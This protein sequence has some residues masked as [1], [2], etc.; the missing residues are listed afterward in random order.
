MII[1][2]FNNKGG[3]GK[4][5]YLYHLAHTIARERKNVLMVD[6]DPQCNLTSY[7][8]NDAAIG[9]SFDPTRGNSLYLAIEPLHQSMGDIRDR[10][11]SQPQ[12]V[13]YPTLWL[14]PGD[15]SLSEFEDTLGDTWVRAKGG[16]A[17]DVRKQSGIFRFIS[18]AAEKVDAEFTFIDLGPNLGPLNRTVLACCD[19][20]IVPVAPDLFSIRGTEN[21]GKKLVTWG[22]EWTQIAEA[23][24][25]RHEIAIPN[26]RPIFLGYVTQQHNQRNNADGMTKGWQIF[27]HRL[28]AAITDNIV[29][30]LAPHNQVITWADGGNYNLGEIPNFHSMIPYSQEARM[31]LFDCGS[32]QGLN[33]AHITTARDSISLFEPMAQTLIGLA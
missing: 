31:P 22:E 33:G 14:I 3:V 4:T 30:R 8:L 19:Y 23:S 28:E 21:L 9:R 25:G 17:A 18:A 2:I 11:P 6:C 27:G 10:Q 32:R 29:A 24:A 26:G 12:R 1:G 20:F 16:N 7:S 13:R 15:P 5:T